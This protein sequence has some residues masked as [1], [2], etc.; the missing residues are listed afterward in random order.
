MWLFDLH[1][2]GT[3]DSL[4]AVPTPDPV[5]D[6]D[7]YGSSVTPVGDLDGN[8]TPDLVVG[9]PGDDRTGIDRG[10]LWLLYRNPNGTLLKRVPIRPSL[11]FGGRTFLPEFTGFGGAVA[12]LGDLDGDGNQEL[13]VGATGSNGIPGNEGQVRV[14]SVASDGSV[15]DQALLVV[16]G[17]QEG[18]LFGSALANLGDFDADGVEDLLVGA[19]GDDDGVSNAGAIRLVR[20]TAAGTVK[21][22]SKI[23]RT[24]G[25]FTGSLDNGDSFGSSVARI[26]DMNGDGVADVAVG[27]I[28]DDDGSAN[29]GAVW[30]LFLN[31]SGTVQSHQKISRTQGGL[32]NHAHTSFGGDLTA[33]GDLNGDTVPDLAVGASGGSTGAVF[34]LFLNADGTVQSSRIL[35]SEFTGVAS[36]DGLGSALASLGDWDADGRP[37]FAVGAFLR[38]G[39]PTG[40]DFTSIDAALAAA[41]SG[42]TILVRGGTYASGVGW[43]PIHGKS[44][45]IQAWNPRNVKLSDTVDVRNLTSSQEVR[46]SGLRGSGIESIHLEANE[47]RVWIDDCSVGHAFTVAFAPGMTVSDC[48]AVVLN[49]TAVSGH[50]TGTTGTPGLL[51]GGGSR[52]HAYDCDFTG[53]FG[54]AGPPYTYTNRHPGGPGVRLTSTDDFLF[55]SACT[56]R[57]L[58]PWAGGDCSEASVALETVGTVRSRD[59]TFLRLSA[60]CPG[61]TITGTVRYLSGEGLSLSVNNPTR[62]SEA[63]QFAVEGPPGTVVVVRYS[64]TSGSTFRLPHRGTDLLGVDR[65]SDTIGVIGTDGSLHWTEN[66]GFL[67]PGYEILPFY[68]QA[69]YLLPTAPQVPGGSKTTAL[70]NPLP[71]PVYLGSG[72]VISRLN[73]DL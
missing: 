19:S 62:E 11:A 23:S 17:L 54:A 27:A 20:L 7:G 50:R 2:D 53:G 41:T 10:V 43:Y 6:F 25:G 24:V 3:L 46:L 63:T 12:S 60:T 68:A 40:A 67:P 65:F 49:R 14:L 59:S 16:G 61:S 39:Q 48:A 57:G 47:G 34:V 8:G 35:T 44:L 15:V 33:L 36:G 72:I 13:A 38:D 32:G 9:A 29:V 52:V 58:G 21:S 71:S 31:A 28:G 69:L 18:D 42:D 55:L 51:I 70:P 30:V 26:G 1:P 45:T 37:D 64:L 56:L 4:S 5:S 66:L 22:V 73:D